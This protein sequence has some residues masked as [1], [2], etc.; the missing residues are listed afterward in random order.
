VYQND[1]AG[2]NFGFSH[3]NPHPAIVSLAP[4]SLSSSSFKQRQRLR[5]GA[6]HPGHL[7]F[8]YAYFTVTSQ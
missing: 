3:F 6:L 7:L 4:L 1:T 8:S 5:A 2:A